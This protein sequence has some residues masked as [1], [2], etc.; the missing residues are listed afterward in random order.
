M[1]A[2]KAGKEELPHE[3]LRWMGVVP[4]K[5]LWRHVK[6]SEEDNLGK[7]MTTASFSAHLGTK[8]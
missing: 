8:S 5:R 7:P 2:K 6:L 1:C 4:K 3:T